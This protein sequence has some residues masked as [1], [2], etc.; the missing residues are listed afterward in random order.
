MYYIIQSF[1]I[2][3]GGLGFSFSLEKYEKTAIMVT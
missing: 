3:A 1:Y 2:P